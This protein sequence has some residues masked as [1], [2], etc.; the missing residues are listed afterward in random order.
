MKLFVTICMTQPWLLYT[1][2]VLQLTGASVPKLYWAHEPATCSG[3][4]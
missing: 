4:I 2:G 1:S 3:V